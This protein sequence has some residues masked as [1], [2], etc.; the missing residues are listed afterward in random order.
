M[1]LISLFGPLLMILA[2]YF[3][4]K[5]HITKREKVGIIIAFIGSLIIA[6]EPISSNGYGSQ[7]LLGNLLIFASLISSATSGF[8]VKKLMRKGF[9][10]SFLVNITFF[11][12]LITLL[13]VVL[14]NYS[15]NSLLLLATSTPIKYH[16]GVLYMALISGTFAYILSNRAQKTIELSEVALFAYIHPGIS[17]VFALLLL[18][19]IMT[20]QILLGGIIAVVGVVIAEIK[21]KRYNSSL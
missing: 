2:G 7:R 10:P 3:F 18:G 14:I 4:L 21:K 17:A 9:P 16:L 5:E 13:P 11:V 20:P 12:G 6:L 8:L 15:P 1:S 19:D